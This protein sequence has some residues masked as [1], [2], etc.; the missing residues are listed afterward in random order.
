MPINLNGYIGANIRCSSGGGFSRD[1]AMETLAV[2]SGGYHVVIDD[3]VDTDYPLSRRIL[4]NGGIVAARFT[5]ND[6]DDD[7]DAHFT[8]K[9][10]AQIQVARMN[11]I[12]KHPNLFGYGGNE[13]GMTEPARQEEFLVQYLDELGHNGYRGVIGNYSYLN[14]PDPFD[15]FALMPRARAAAARWNAFWGFHEGTDEDYPYFDDAWEAGAIGQALKWREKYGF[16]IWLTE[17]AGS[18]NAWEGY[19]K[20]YADKG[21]TPTWVS[22]LYRT[23][24]NYCTKYNIPLSMFTMFEWRDGFEFFNDLLLLRDVGIINQTFPVQEKPIVTTIDMMAHICPKNSTL[25][26]MSSG[27]NMQSLYDPEGYGRH[28]KNALWEEIWG[29]TIDGVQYIMRGMD[30]SSYPLAS[31]GT[32]YALYRDA[33]LKKYGAKWLPRFAEVRKTYVRD[34]VWVQKYAAQ[35]GVKIANGSGR[36]ITYFQIVDYHIIWT[37]PEGRPVVDVA[38]CVYSHN[39]NLSQVNE[40]YF[41]AKGYGLVGYRDPNMNVFIVREQPTPLPAQVVL[42]WWTR[43]PFPGD[44]PMFPPPTTGGV[45]ARLTKTP[46]GIINIRPQ[47]NPNSGSTGSGNDI[48]DLINGDEVTYYPNNMVGEWWY[49]EPLIQVPRTGAQQPAVKGW[50]SR[51][52]GA[53]AFTE[54]VPPQPP[55]EKRVSFTEEQIEEIKTNLEAIDTLKN[56]IIDSANEIDARNIRISEILSEGVPLENGGSF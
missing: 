3:D 17:F 56:K 25:Y 36:D 11:K 26:R 18:K 19:K 32:V 5:L 51:Q 9:Q 29:E 31:G 8:G 44:D 13:L 24:V 12:G 27:E 52:N 23:A 49:I 28:Q 1:K 46:Q 48:G 38:E 53:V 37:T 30:T 43:P 50:V 42:S 15:L 41:Y 4:D 2:M 6:Q 33:E 10:L 16:N 20:L 35:N 7:A 55:A 47:P 22:V 21:G 14:P 39:A 40:R 34:Q 54:V 45:R